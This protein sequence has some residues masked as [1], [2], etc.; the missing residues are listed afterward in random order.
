MLF[1]DRIGVLATTVLLLLGW[2]AAVSNAHDVLLRGARTTGADGQ[3]ALQV[4]GSAVTSLRLILATNDKDLGPLE[5]DQKIYLGDFP[6]GSRFNIDALVSG[7]PRSVRFAYSGNS[8][9]GRI[10][11]SAPYAMCGNSGRDFTPCPDPVL[12][13]G[14]HTVTATPFS[15]SNAQ[16]TA[17]TPRTVRFT[18]LAGT[19][20]TAAPVPATGCKVPKASRD[21]STRVGRSILWPLTVLFLSMY[22]HFVY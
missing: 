4:A 3:R 20:T 6:A 16:G 19:S 22:I 1:L 12:A 21:I 2:F 10:E 17:G 8:I 14:S 15:L 13:L 11:G 5:D 7:S 18:I 9:Y